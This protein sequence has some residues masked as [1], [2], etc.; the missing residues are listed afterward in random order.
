MLADLTCRPH[1][2]MYHVFYT[3]AIFGSILPRSQCSCCLWPEWGVQAAGSWPSM[4]EEERAEAAA[5]SSGADA[6]A[7]QTLLAKHLGKNKGV[8]KAKVGKLP[9]IAAAVQT[10]MATWVTFAPPNL[11]ERVPPMGRIKDPTAAPIQ[12]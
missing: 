11:S 3:V 9:A 1:L 4:A 7:G 5:A 10:T 12:E 2:Q 6:G 8:P